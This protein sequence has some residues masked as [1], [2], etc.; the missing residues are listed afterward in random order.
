MGH[1]NLAGF[2]LKDIQ[3]KNEKKYNTSLLA[4]HLALPKL[5]KP[6]LVK[7]FM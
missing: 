7:I 6:S 4:L 1:I 5:V 2:L 3:M